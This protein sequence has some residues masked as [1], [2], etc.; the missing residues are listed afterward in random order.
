M[1][2]NCPNSYTYDNRL[3]LSMES[4]P[5]LSSDDPWTIAKNRFVADLTSEEVE[6]F[7]NASLESLYY[8]ASNYEREDSQKSRTR[9]ILDKL[10]PLVSAVED[11]GKALDTITNIAPLYLAPI[12]G[13][14]RVVLVMAKA[15]GK[16][17]DRMVE[18]FRRIGNVLP[19]FRKLTATSSRFL[20]LKLFR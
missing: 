19:R 16:F 12:W 9:G 18:T 20:E 5:A 2:I 7:N 13:C 1:R 3:F 4:I 11:Y 8:G 14:I 10:A 15:H 17:Y 6:I